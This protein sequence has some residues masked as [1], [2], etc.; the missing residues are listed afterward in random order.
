VLSSRKS[1]FAAVGA[2]GVLGALTFGGIAYAV[3]GDEPVRS[4][5]VTVVDQPGSGESTEAPRSGSEEQP[6]GEKRDCPEKS[7]G[8]S[9]GGQEQPESPGQAPSAPSEQQPAPGSAEDL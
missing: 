1:K 5:Y 3:G 4:E 2:A 8:Q 9:N 6:R 7:G